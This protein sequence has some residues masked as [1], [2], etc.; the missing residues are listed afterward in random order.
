MK[1][2]RMRKKGREKK[3]QLN[4]GSLNTNS[5]M[6]KHWVDIHDEEEMK[7]G[8]FRIKVLKYTKSSF[9]RQVLESVLLHENLEH[10]LLN[11]KVNT[12]DL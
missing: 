1:N 9:E 2:V 7:E 11:S 12:I 4:C 8:V 3:H 10:N 5:Y 6:L